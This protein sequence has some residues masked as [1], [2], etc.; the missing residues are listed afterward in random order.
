[1]CIVGA[2]AAGI[3]L[4]LELDGKPGSVCVLE[5]GGFE[6]DAATQS[7]AAGRNVAMPTISLDCGPAAISRRHDQSLGRPLPPAGSDGL[8]A[9]RCGSSGWPIARSDLDGYYVK[10][11]EYCRLGD[12]NYDPAFWATPDAPLRR[13][14]AGRFSPPS[15]FKTRSASDASIAIACRRH[16]MYGYSC[17]PMR[18]GS[19]RPEMAPRSPACTPGPCRARRFA[20]PRKYSSLRPGPSRTPAYC[21]RATACIRKASATS[22]ISWAGTSWNT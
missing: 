14:T 21:C 15:S 18:P 7:L 2:G 16:G 8:R 13:V 9:A 22:T 1:M 12:V 3:T 4:A 19:M 11:H 5:S 6:Y 17:R 20:L 10:A